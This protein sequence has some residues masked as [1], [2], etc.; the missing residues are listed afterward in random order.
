MLM[1]E[2]RMM[3]KKGGRI[4][5]GKK[6]I[7][8]FGV[9]VALI[10][11]FGVLQAQKMGPDSG[12]DQGE[13]QQGQGWYCPWCGRGEGMGPGMMHPGWGSGMRHRGWGHHMG[14]GWGGGPQSPSGPSQ[15][16]QPLTKS[17]VKMLLENYLKNTGNPNLKLGDVSEK[18]KFY[19]AK[20]LTKDGSLVDKIQV[21]KYT[22]WFRSAYSI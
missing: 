19:E 21:H 7:V 20:I 10:A 8:I 15:Q 16:T 11:S 13:P 5:M 6:G 9:I 17:E 2:H 14:P 3:G 18:E 1:L 22:G 4:H 12:S